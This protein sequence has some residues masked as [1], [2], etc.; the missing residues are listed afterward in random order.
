M[1]YK[2][3]VTSFLQIGEKIL[4]VRRSQRVGTNR[5]KWSAV[6]GY[7]EGAEQPLTRALTEIHEEVGLA[8]EQINL[9][10][11]G[12]SLR[13][14]DAESDTVWVVHPFLFEARSDSVRLDWENVEY[15][16]VKPEELALYQTVP[17]LRET[18]DR[19][20]YDL[21]RVPTSLAS[22]IHKVEQLG[23]DR[24]HG[25]SFLGKQGVMLLSESAEGSDAR[26]SP[27]LF[28]HL[29]LVAL[30]LRN[31]Q[32]EM[33]NVWNLAGRLLYRVDQGRN[34]ESV[35]E[36]RELIQREAA[37][38][39][40]QVGEDSENTSRT[41]TQI[42]PAEGSILTHSYSNTV[43]RSLELGFKG[44]RSLHVYAT[45][46]YPGL[47]GKQFAK[48]LIARGV[49]VTLIAD[50][51]VSSVIRNVHLVLVGADSV[52]RDGSLVHKTGTREIGATAKKHGVSLYS[53][54]ESVKFSVQDFLG[55]PLQIQSTLFDVT[56]P[57]LISG[58]IT[59]QGQ[60]APGHV[61]ARLKDLQRDVY[62]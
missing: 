4:L 58:Y 44:G 53:T 40:E 46:S 13:A 24:V 39:L 38:I 54:C 32:P 1:N 20:L 60:L 29:L 14:F 25:A 52:L 35:G 31:A 10:R 15:K 47:E 7:L 2:Q 36:V 55:E 22:I 3:V 45:E 9:V 42:L 12:E 56:P 34:G 37:R 11:I 23:E 8:S 59:E 18:L 19:V 62:P 43:L 30:R 6:S 21:Q 17:K 48:E 49:P 57:D 50:S 26:D 51:A 27:S 16:W 61:E 41:A 33:A 5:G 28:S